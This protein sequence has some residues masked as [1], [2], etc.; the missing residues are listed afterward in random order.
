MENYF[1][2]NLFPLKI[3]LKVFACSR[4][5]FSRKSPPV[6]RRLKLIAINLAID[7]I[8]PFAL[9]LLLLS[10]T[11]VAYFCL[12]VIDM[13]LHLLHFRSHVV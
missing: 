7:I 2:L 10:C 3:P 11:V 4:M 13:S 9:D 8:F 6:N 12:L 1:L 5:T